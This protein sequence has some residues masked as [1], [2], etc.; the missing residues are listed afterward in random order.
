MHAGVA[1]R[2]H[3]GISGVG[4]LRDDELDALVVYRASPIPD[5]FVPV[6]SLGS[7]AMVL[8]RR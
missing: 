6:A 7:S 2:E 5:G 8:R 4:R 1:E 3:R